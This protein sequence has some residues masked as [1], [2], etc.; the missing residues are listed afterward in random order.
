MLFARFLAV[1]LLL[2]GLGPTLLL[3]WLRP[4]GW[5]L[6][7]LAAVYAVLG[8]G[9]WKSKR[10]ALPLA[11]ALTLPQLVVVSSSSFS[12]RFYALA[13][14]GY[15]LVPAQG[16]VT[17]WQS[18]GLGMNMAAGYCPPLIVDCAFTQSPSFVLF[19]FVALALLVL[20]IIH[21]WTSRRAAKSNLAA[22][23]APARAGSIGATVAGVRA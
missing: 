19:N 2:Q 13:S 1:T 12:W 10:W 11:F 8:A 15:G 6:A 18:F 21:A 14:G 5:F 7:I 20:L 3:G 16:A 4:G 23:R 17:S 22:R 9:M